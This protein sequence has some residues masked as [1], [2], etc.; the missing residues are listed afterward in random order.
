MERSRIPNRKGGK[1][2][3]AIAGL[4]QHRRVVWCVRWALGIVFIV[5]A[6]GK[7]ADPGA[8]AGEIAA[9][10]LLPAHVVNLFA[11]AMPWVELLVGL[12]LV[13]AIAP[14]SGAL[15]AGLMGLVFVVAVASAM[16]RGLNIECGC[17]SVVKSKVGW[18]HIGADVLLVAL[19]AVVLMQPPGT[20]QPP[21]A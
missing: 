4:M 1:P 9:Y 15:L 17:I 18:K 5:S 21:V 12:S 19:S 13:N 7:I 3:S 10:R 8:F 11:I 20:R 6:L 2:M 16:A 14:K